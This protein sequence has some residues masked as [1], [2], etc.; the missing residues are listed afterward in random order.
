MLEQHLYVLFFK[1]PH[2]AWLLL[3]KFNHASFS[4]IFISFEK[5]Y[6][7]LLSGLSL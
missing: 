6:L 1:H 2:H 5:V 4:N 7:V 3:L